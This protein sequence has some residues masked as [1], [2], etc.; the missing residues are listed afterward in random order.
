MKRPAF[1]NIPITNFDIQ[2]WVEYLRLNNFGGVISRDQV[3]D[4]VPQHS[5][6]INLNESDEPGSHWVAMFFGSDLVL[7]FDSFG[8]A[9]PQELLTLCEKHG[10]N[11]AYN[12]AQYQALTSVLC[13][14]YCLFFLNEIS[15]RLR[16]PEISKN[17]HQ[18]LYTVF[19]EALEPLSHSDMASNERFIK[20][21]FR[22]V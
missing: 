12:N 8:L 14:Y 16:S 1:K 6:V 10:I 18:S 22:E 3:I 7:Y 17:L 2:N 15:K 4:S 9:P 20:K 5:Y 11:Y 21:Y 19:N 13:G